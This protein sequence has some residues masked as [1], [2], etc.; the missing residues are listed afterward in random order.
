[1]TDG[2]VSRLVV[3]D[4]RDLPLGIV[5]KRDIARFLLDD[6][7][8]R[9]LKEIGVGETCGGPVHMISSDISVSE[10]ARIFN[11]KNLTCAVVSEN[12][13][14]SGIV[15]E[16]DLCQYFSL[17]QSGGFKVGD[18]MTTDFF[19]AKSNYPIMHV[20]HALVF[21]QPTIPVIDEKLVGILTLTDVLSINQNELVS[22]D[23]NRAL[24]MTTK[25]LMT[26]NPI[27]TSEETELTQA[28]KVILGN[29][30]SG[31]PVTDHKS[32]L[33]G[34]LTKHDI[35]KAMASTRSLPPIESVKGRIA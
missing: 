24:L 6:S 34:L 25:E 27:V 11:T 9:G 10:A 13:M 4:K 12:D 20:A 31:L 30:K 21:R 3:T 5:S 1:M 7:T 29:R 22:S 18:F 19:F 28:A 26:R 2:R 33:V 16:T 35:V 23:P 15:T 8:P 32:R 17:N 14:V